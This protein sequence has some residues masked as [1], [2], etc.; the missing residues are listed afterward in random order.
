M[1]AQG[2]NEADAVAGAPGDILCFDDKNEELVL[3]VEVKDHAI[4]LAELRASTSKARQS[5]NPIR[6]LLLAAPGIRK[7]DQDAIGSKLHE[8]WASGLNVSQV[9]ILAL[10]KHC[11]VL[12]DETWRIRL[13]REIG[14]ELDTKAQHQHRQMWHELLSQL[15]ET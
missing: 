13:L 1:E 3:V 4:T 6:Q 5:T 7:A 8:A 12:L 14:A 10:L 11:L 9:E 2:I 15:T